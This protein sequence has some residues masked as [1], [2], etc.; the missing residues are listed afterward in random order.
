ML[1]SDVVA[2]SDIGQFRRAIVVEYG[3]PAAVIE[4]VS[5][6]DDVGQYRR[7]G[8]VEHSS[9]VVPCPVFAEGDIGQL[10]RTVVGVDTAPVARRRGMG[11]SRVLVEGDVDQCRRTVV[12]VVHATAVNAGCV[13]VEGDVGQCRGTAVDVEHAA[14]VFGGIAAEGDVR[15]HWRAGGF[16]AHTAALAVA[17][18]RRDPVPI[19]GDVGQHRGTS[20]V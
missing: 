11:K 7:P 9:A 6:E 8:S 13:P 18:R 15:Q 3:P 4:P 14:A 1:A 17:N 20:N 2:K 5:A 12:G 16:V 10:R 19:E